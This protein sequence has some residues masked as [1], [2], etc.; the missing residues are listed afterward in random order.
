MGQEMTS[1][2]RLS[3]EAR[4]VGETQN[5]LSFK[6]ALLSCLEPT[7]IT[8]KDQIELLKTGRRPHA[9]TDV[10]EQRHSPRGDSWWEDKLSEHHSEGW[11]AV[12]AAGFQGNGSH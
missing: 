2:L 5:H 4:R 7:E 6:R 8:H 11:R 1:F 12:S 10:Y 9:D 3:S